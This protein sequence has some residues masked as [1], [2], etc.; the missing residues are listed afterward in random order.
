[1][2]ASDFFI[3]VTVPFYANIGRGAW[4][5]VKELWRDRNVA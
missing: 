1:M 4:A 5:L 2:I 3:F